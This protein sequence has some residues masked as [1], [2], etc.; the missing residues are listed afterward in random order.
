LW[1]AA[2]DPVLE[3]MKITG[4]TVFAAGTSPLFTGRQVALVASAMFD[5]VNGIEP[6]RYEPIHVTEK[7]PPHASPAAAAIQAAYAILGKLYPTRAALL[8]PQRN[9]SIAA[10]VLGPGRSDSIQA[11]VDWGQAVADS[12]WAWRSTD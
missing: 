11:G 3:W 6:R 9:A 4:D 10:I 1:A 5:A 8:T 2:Q 12:I 7:A